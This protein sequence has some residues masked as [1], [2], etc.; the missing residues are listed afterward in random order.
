[1]VLRRLE[2]DLA[3]AVAEADATLAASFGEGVAGVV[4]DIVLYDGSD[5]P[6]TLPAAPGGDA[7]VAWSA[8][9]WGPDPAFAAVGIVAAAWT[10]LTLTAR[11]TGLAA[12]A[13]RAAE[14]IP[15]SAALVVGAL[16]AAAAWAAVDHAL[17]KYDELQ[18]RAEFERQLRALLEARREATAETMIAAIGAK[19]DRLA[20]T[21]IRDLRDENG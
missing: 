6:L 5:I 7:I 10:L 12:R 19:S 9:G 15:G 11:L 20:A 4:R 13:R 3:A 2:F 17:L 8:S 1:M 21:T 18:H 14:A 16:T